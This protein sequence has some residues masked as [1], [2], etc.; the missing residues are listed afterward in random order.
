MEVDELDYCP[1][2]A[3]IAVAGSSQN[4]RHNLFDMLF[5]LDSR[6]C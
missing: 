3:I 5:A 4:S 1:L 6:E 2:F